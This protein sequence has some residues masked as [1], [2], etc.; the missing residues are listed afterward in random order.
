MLVGAREGV[1]ERPGAARRRWSLR[2]GSDGPWL[3]GLVVLAAALRFATLTH[4]S[5]WLDE[6]QAAH[7]TALSFGAMLH[8]WSTTEWNGPLYLLL[9]WPWAHVFGSGEAGLRSLSA[10]LGVAV[11]PLLYLSGRQLVSSRAGLVAAAFAAVN[12]F[13][14]WYSQEAREYMLLV[15]L[16]AAS[17]WCFA[18]VWRQPTARAL[19]CWAALSAL[20]LLTAYFAALLIV[21]EGALLVWRV[22]SRASVMA[23][24]AQAIVLAPLIP[25]LEPRLRSATGF[26][27]ELPL[28]VRLQEIPVSFGLYPVYQGSAV[29]DGLLAAA[30]VAGAVIVVLLIGASAAELRG[31]GVAAVLAGVV[32]V[33]PL[34][35]AL[36]GHDD[37]IA[38]TLMPGWLPLAIVIG[39]ACAA[40]RARLAG[41]CL[42]LLMLVVFVFGYVRVNTD[43]GY[44]K[45]DWRGVAAALGRPLGPRAIVAYDS[46]FATGPLSFYLPRVPW[47]GPGA[48]PLPPGTVAI[49]ELD[50][51]GSVGDQLSRRLAGASL[52]ATRTVDG[53]Q[54]ARFALQP[55]SRVTAGTILA[56]GEGLRSP[57]AAGAGVIFQGASA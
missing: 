44:D 56:R 27:V 10:V 24:A 31:A 19:W 54:V 30:V 40:S 52:I 15:A 16:C 34:L 26:I 2:G 35:F 8:A 23:L 12:P 57:A 43:A 29:S 22:R 32:L 37:V 39:A 3:L 36:A 45:P 42:A 33:V 51:V 11:V 53:H 18:R 55:G 46:T 25:H 1:A 9:A 50:V 13:M 4:Q 49:R 21:A 38:R 41:A 20:A 6:A 5:Y 28:S 17:L 48:A 14:I 47:A 7:E